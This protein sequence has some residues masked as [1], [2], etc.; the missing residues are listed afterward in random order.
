V[1][2]ASTQASIVHSQVPGRSTVKAP[3]QRTPCSGRR[4]R[5]AATPA[6]P[7]RPARASARPHAGRRG[8]RGRCRPTR[9]RRRR[10][11]RLIG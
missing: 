3:S 11:S 2:N 5:R 8:R 7:R 6:M 1:A 4:P 10:R 9:A